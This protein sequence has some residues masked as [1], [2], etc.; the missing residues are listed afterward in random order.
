M[1]FLVLKENI[2][3]TRAQ[4]VQFA[5]D[6]FEKDN[7]EMA[8]EHVALALDITAQRRYRAKRST[9]NNY[10]RLLSEYSWLLEIMAFNGMDIDKSVFR[11]Y[12][13]EETPEP[14]FRDLIYHVVR[15]KL[16]HDQGI[17]ENLTE[18]FSEGYWISIYD[19]KMP[20]KVKI[21]VPSGHII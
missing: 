20:I 19:S 4:R 11:N 10:K 3:I 21:I 17:P 1:K 7:F 8:L 18:K 6:E 12:P 16:L 5:I 14:T 9:A 13:I 15:C 2:A